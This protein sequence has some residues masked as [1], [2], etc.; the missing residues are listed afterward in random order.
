M[1]YGLPIGNSRYEGELAMAK[2]VDGKL[3]QGGKVNKGTRVMA[4]RCAHAF[5]DERYGNG[6]RVFNGMKDAWTCSVCS[7]IKKS[8]G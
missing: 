2:T 3:Q 6:Q 1:K 8:E 7:T 5:Q 4:C